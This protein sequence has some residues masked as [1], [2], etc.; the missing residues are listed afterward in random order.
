MKGAVS[1]ET[2]AQMIGAVVLGETVDLAAEA[3]ALEGIAVQ[4]D[5]E[6]IKGLKRCIRQSAQIV[7]M[8]AKFHSNL[9]KAG[10]YIAGNVLAGIKNIRLGQTFF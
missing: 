3:A 1:E 4:A 6:M 2:E 8:N 7:A 9:K 10:Q 5:L